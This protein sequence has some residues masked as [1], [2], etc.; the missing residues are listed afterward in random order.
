M[1]EEDPLIEIHL[2][3]VEM[4]IRQQFVLYSVSWRL[5]RIR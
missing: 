5:W 2:Q 1:S 3:G 4:G